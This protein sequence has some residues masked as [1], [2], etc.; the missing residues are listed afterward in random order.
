MNLL[1]K[2]KKLLS[3]GTKSTLT[4]SNINKRFELMGRTGQGSMSKVWRARDRES[5]R[6]VCLKILDKLKCET[7]AESRQA[8]D[9]AFPQINVLINRDEEA[10]LQELHHDLNDRYSE[11]GVTLAV[12]GPWPPYTF[13]TVA[14]G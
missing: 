4:I 10:I 12:T 14:N 6:I 13:A 3:P 2:I 11:E 5:G 1:D 9:G 8:R 7:V